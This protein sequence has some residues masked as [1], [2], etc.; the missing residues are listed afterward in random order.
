MKG[1]A[2]FLV[3]VV[4]AGIVYT[5]VRPHSQGPSLVNALTGGLANLVKAGM[6][7]GQ[8]WNS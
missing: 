6:G 3:L 1:A 8:T 7:A 5:L 2:E 4:Y